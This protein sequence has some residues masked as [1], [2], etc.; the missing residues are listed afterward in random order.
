MSGPLLLTHPN[1]LRHGTQGH[2]ERPDRITAILEAVAADPD[3]AALEQRYPQP[4]SVAEL[5]L[6]HSA[7]YVEEMLAAADRADAEGAGRWLDPDTWIG[8]GTR[9]A[10]LLAAGA[11]V[12]ATRAVLSGTQASAFSICRP[13]GHHAPA[14]RAMGFCIFNNVAVA[15]GTALR[16][17]C[18]RVAIV[19]F[20][21]HHGN[22]TQDIFYGRDDVLY[23]S[24]HQYGFGFYPGTGAAG[25]TGTGGGEGYNLNIPLAAG[26]GEQQYLEA[27]DGVIGPR[28]LEYAPDLLLVSA[29]FDA[30]RDD[31]LAG[32]ELTAGSFGALAQRLRQWSESC[33]DGRSAWILEG[34]YGLPGLSAGMVEV[35]RTL[36]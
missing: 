23:V 14:D 15:A 33:C 36:L 6:A 35:L 18:S 32:M 9:S 19:D 27:F 28:L 20:D 16:E 30:D 22:G 26:S 5:S 25:E 4:A 7:A 17:G 34:G 24:T 1:C 2:P 12:D 31:P 13:P 3:L 11:A 8:P 10:M 29:G 21:V